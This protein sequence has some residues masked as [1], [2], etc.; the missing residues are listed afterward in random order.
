MIISIELSND[1]YALHEAFEMALKWQH[2]A[3]FH[4]DENPKTI[5]SNHLQ[6]CVHILIHLDRHLLFIR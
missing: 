5:P 4:F 3:Q 6:N 2:D 1:M